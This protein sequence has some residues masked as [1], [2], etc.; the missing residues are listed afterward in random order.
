MIIQN[1]HE[2]NIPRLYHYQRLNLD[3]LRQI[4]FDQKIYFSNPANFNDPWDCRPYFNIPAADDHVACERCIQWFAS[5][6]RKRT[7][8]LD[9]QEHARKVLELRNNRSSF[10]QQIRSFSE[11]MVGEINRIYR[12]YCLSTKADSTLMWSHYTDNHQGICL[13]FAC[14]NIV[15]G[16]AIQIQYS[17]EYPLLDFA[18]DG[19]D[20]L[21]M[22]PL[23]VKSDVWS[24]EG[25]FRVIA[26]EIFQLPR[27]DILRTRSNL[28]RYPPGSLKAVIMG[29]MI[30]QSDAIKLRGII[31]QQFPQRVAL[32]QTVR[33]PNLYSLSIVNC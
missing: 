20:P 30:P 25:E 8:C 9:E 21:G 24:Y 3:W 2:L 11:A 17:R 15:F 4:L 16:S 28:L 6:A 33:S 19:Q 14:D 13:E 10:E 27:V 26:Q 12:V 18:I 5:A 31:D 1:A 32:K 23:F 22:L 7:P 29:C